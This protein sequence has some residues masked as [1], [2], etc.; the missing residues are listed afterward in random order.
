MER[1]PNQRGQFLKKRK[2]KNGFTNCRSTHT[3]STSNIADTTHPRN[4]KAEVRISG[5]CLEHN[6][7]GLVHHPTDPHRPNDGER[8]EKGTFEKR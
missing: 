1:L 7:G 5:L 4:G 3:D 6:Q 2:G 8:K